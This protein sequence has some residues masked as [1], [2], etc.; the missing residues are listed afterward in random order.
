[1]G[2]TETLLE[3]IYHDVLSEKNML[4]KEFFVK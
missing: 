2:P 3:G 1:M 4:V